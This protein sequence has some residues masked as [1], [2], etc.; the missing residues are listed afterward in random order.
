[1]S[2]VRRVPRGDKVYLYEY[3]SIREKGGKVKSKYIRA[4]GVESN[5]EKVP[6]KKEKEIHWKPPERSYRAGDVSVLWELAQELH[7]SETIDRIC[8]SKKKR[9][10]LSTGVLISLWAINRALDP[11]SATQMDNW[12]LGTELPALAG[13]SEK[14]LNKDVFLEALDDI[15]MFDPSADRIFDRTRELDEM[16]YGIWRNQHPLPPGTSETLAYDMTT[17]VIYGDTCPL[18]DKGY[19]PNNDRHQ[20]INLTVLISKYD[21]HPL[22]HMVHPGN[23]A[24][25]TTMQGLL[26]RL[27]DFNIS[28]GTIIWDRGNTSKNTVTTLE[29][30]GWKVICGISKVSTEVKGIIKNNP[31]PETPKYIV[32]CKEKG[33]LYAN[34]IRAT[35]Y[36]KEREV[37]VYKNV[38][39]AAESVIRRNRALF[40]ISFELVQLQNENGFSK[41]EELRKAVNEIIGK[42]K[43]YFIIK[44][45]D[46]E[47]EVKFA[48]EISD[49][50]M[51]TAKAM[52]G[53]FVLYSTDESYSAPEVVKMYMEKDVVEKS[54]QVMKSVEDIKPVRHRLESRVKAYIFVCMLAFR[55]R[56]ALES[57]IK[58][59]DS[60]DMK[61]TTG[62]FLRRLKRVE[63]T[64]IDL[65]DEIEVCHMNMTGDIR[66]QLDALNMKSLLVN[67]RVKKE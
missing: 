26:P 50:R 37:V 20:Q 61:L 5:V 2:W 62:D 46:D 49:E 17:I 54:F 48:W 66:K 34:K 55:L 8:G 14:S 60:K 6:I 63:R 4:L 33:K 3:E 42:W 15:C 65:E 7:F 28:E 52:D 53:T 21:S 36:G 32:P 67:G 39:V 10:G 44:Y 18:T 16:L 45:P 12:L 35:L 22:A 41:Q 23:H 47:K 31:I 30:N 27:S 40:E 64:D 58:S 43:S 29:R 51:E 56:I 24:S 19:N 13:I 1:M 59:S 9:N 11:E 57:M 38:K 25:M